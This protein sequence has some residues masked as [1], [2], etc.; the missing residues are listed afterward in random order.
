[1]RLHRSAFPGKKTTVEQWVSEGDKLVESS[2][3]PI[4]VVLRVAASFADDPGVGARMHRLPG[5]QVDRNLPKA[6]LSLGARGIAIDIDRRRAAASRRRC[7]S[8]HTREAPISVFKTLRGA[9]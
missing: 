8:T 3:R 1:M 6:W 2:N 4:V 7:R 5:S 9:A